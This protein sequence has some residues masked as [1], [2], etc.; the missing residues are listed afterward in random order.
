M[1]W[2]FTP[3]PFQ[4]F[5]TIM[6]GGDWTNVQLWYRMW[7]KLHITPLC[8]VLSNPIVPAHLRSILLYIMWRQISFGELC[9][10][11]F[12]PN[13]HKAAN[14]FSTRGT[15]SK[16]INKVLAL[17]H[18]TIDSIGFQA[19]HDPHFQFLTSSKI[20]MIYKAACQIRKRAPKERY[21]IRH[22]L[23]ILQLYLHL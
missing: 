2:G 17:L 6:M 21:N 22:C 14:L 18:T 20:L 7:F 13:P 1:G 4:T 19:I 10:L 23:P 15:L 16:V 12:W 8:R 3:I 11:H 5:I 9:I